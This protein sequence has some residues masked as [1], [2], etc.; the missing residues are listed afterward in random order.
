MPEAGDEIAIMALY[1]G[2]QE[3]LFVFSHY[4]VSFCRI[5]DG[6][7]RHQNLNLQQ[8]DVAEMLEE[9]LQLRSVS[10]RGSD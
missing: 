7:K 4:A 6:S 5:A 3:R 1:P 8:Y 10:S 2:K 9:D